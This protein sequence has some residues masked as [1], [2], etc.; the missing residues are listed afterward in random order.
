FA[1]AIALAL[2]A[3]TVYLRDLE[4]LVEVAITVL[5]W[6]SPIV[7]SFSFVSGA[8]GGSW[9]EELYLANPVTLAVLGMQKGLWMAGH[10]QAGVADWPPDLA[11]RM[12]IATAIALALVWL[13]QRLFSR[14]QG[15]FAQEL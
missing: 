13:A 4:H 5:F 10:E 6:A 2:S 8:I 11:V 15:N 1:L 3:L 9:L 12:L 14:L 7:Y